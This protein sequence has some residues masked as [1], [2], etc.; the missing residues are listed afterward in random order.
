[1]ANTPFTNT[2]RGNNQKSGWGPLRFGAIFIAITVV[3]TLWSFT[4]VNPFANPYELKA[5][6]KSANELKVRSPVR[7]AGVEVGKVKKVEHLPDSDKAIVTMNIKKEGLPIKRDARLKIRSRLFL[8]GNYYVDVHPGS[9][10][11]KTLADGGTIP[12]SQTASPVQFGQ[13][14]TVLQRDTREDLQT[15]LREYSHAL[16][17][18]GADGFNE[19]I[20]HWEEAYRNTAMA[21]RATLGTEKGDLHRLLRGQGRVFGALAKDEEKLKLFVTSLNR[22]AAA[23]A[24]EDDA[25]ERTIPR[26]RNVLRTGRPALASLNSALPTVR[27]FARDALPAARTSPA[28]LDAQLPLLRQLRRLVSPREGGG[29]VRD[30]RP[31]VPF[32]VRLNK[33]SALT[34]Q[35][36]RALSS[37]QNNVLLPFSKTPIPDPDFPQNSGEPFFEQSQR[38][39]VGLAGE[40]RLSDANSPFFRV[41]AGS[42]P[43]VIAGTGETGEELF[44]QADFPIEGAR[45]VSPTKRP[46]FRPGAPCENQEPP[47]L[48]AAAGPGDDTVVPK[49]VDSLLN[50]K[51][52]K[53]A[54]EEFDKLTEHLQRVAKGQP[55]VDPLDFS[56]AGELLLAKRLKINPPKKKEAA[57]KGTAAP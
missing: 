16:E 37:C 52:E 40:S 1:M 33:Q 28:T 35:E 3:V 14:L 15:F 24:R 11:A 39:F 31:T 55:S 34:L 45:P 41:Q 12:P 56:D 48:N 4:K 54:K 23:F 22:T 5:V 36:N 8:E 25:L 9:P 27:A 13:F 21:N 32:L 30:L 57:P 20:G 42:G 7:I 43:T 51:R 10:S 6:F 29:L 2:A 19:A 17:K 49:P 18:E 50:L 38:G 26:L 47:D 53:E 44:A 46:V